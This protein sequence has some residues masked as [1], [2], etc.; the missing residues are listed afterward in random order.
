MN[1]TFAKKVFDKIQ[2]RPYRV[3]TQAGVPAD[4]CFFKGIELL[5]ELGTLGYAVRGRVGETYWD[6]NIFP[7][8]VLKLLNRESEVT[9][10]FIEIL[11]DGE[12]KILDA[13]FHPPLAKFGFPI[14]GWDAGT[15]CFPITRLYTQEESIAFQEKWNQEGMI[16]EYFQREGLFLGALNKWLIS[17]E[18]EDS[19][20]K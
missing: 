19:P 12:W 16:E 17:L 7:K 14:G 13:S 10:F 4:N 20:T 8:E 18:S 11:L 2:S 6:P 9:H 3:S 15:L 1:H 5:Q